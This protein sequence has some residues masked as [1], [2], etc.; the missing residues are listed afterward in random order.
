MR[1]L[2]AQKANIHKNPLENKNRLSG[3]KESYQ[4]IEI[5]GGNVTVDQ[6]FVFWY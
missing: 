1:K 2:V 3:T 5:Y 6:N 4:A